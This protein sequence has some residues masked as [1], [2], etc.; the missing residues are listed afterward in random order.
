MFKFRYCLC[1]ILFT[2]PT[3]NVAWLDGKGDFFFYFGGEVCGLC[4]YVVHKL[5]KEKEVLPEK[6]WERKV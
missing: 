4:V 2:I 1:L 5:D 6:S 3:L